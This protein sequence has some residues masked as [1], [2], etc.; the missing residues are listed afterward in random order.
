MSV[1]INRAEE[2][3]YW[4]T[5]KSGKRISVVLG[6]WFQ[7]IFRFIG[8]CFRSMNKISSNIT[9]SE[10]LVQLWDCPRFVKNLRKYTNI[11]EPSSIDVKTTQKF[12]QERKHQLHFNDT[13]SIY[14]MNNLILLFDVCICYQN[15]SQNRFL[16]SLS[17]SCWKS[18]SLSPSIFSI[19]I[20]MWQTDS[21]MMTNNEYKKFI[22]KQTKSFH[23]FCHHPTLSMLFRFCPSSHSLCTFS[24]RKYLLC[25]ICFRKK[26]QILKFN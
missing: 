14:K 3:E 25:E 22:L 26:G 13:S 9:Y 18:F 24:E 19:G 8:N 15:T 17:P 12:V 16:L 6:I 1:T 23:Y 11:I 4:Q 7:G 2:I 5:A 10:F 20:K 21:K